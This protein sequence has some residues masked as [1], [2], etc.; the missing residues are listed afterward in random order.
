MTQDAAA[1]RNRAVLERMTAEISK[2]NA[3]GD[4]FAAIF[5]NGR[6][7]RYLLDDCPFNFHCAEHDIFL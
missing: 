3:V 1:G 2:V 5:T 4:D 6:A 7:S